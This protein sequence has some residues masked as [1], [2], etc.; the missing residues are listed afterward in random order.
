MYIWF[1]CLEIFPFLIA[2]L[3]GLMRDI[4]FH[5]WTLSHISFDLQDNSSGAIGMFSVVPPK[6]RN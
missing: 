3:V 4:S 5:L 2:V 6:I 1:V